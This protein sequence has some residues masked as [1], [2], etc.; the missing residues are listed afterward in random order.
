MHIAS[1]KLTNWECF[2][3]EHELALGSLIYAIT[4]RCGDDADR[5]NWAG[6]SSLL[7]AVEFALYG[8]HA[9]ARAN[10]WISRGEKAGSV[11]LA[12]D[13]GSRIIRSRTGDAATRVWFYPRA[14]E[15]AY[16]DA[17][18]EA[19][20][21]AIGLGAED[22]RASAYFEQRAMARFV[23]MDPGE[24]MR[25]VS[26]WLRM[27][28]LQR[29]EQAE[30]DAVSA[31]AAEVEKVE[32]S[33]AVQ[34]ELRDRALRNANAK[35]LTEVRRDSDACAADLL[36]AK[37]AYE[38]A[39][40]AVEANEALLAADALRAELAR[41]VE[42]GKALA[43]EVER[44]GQPALTDAD[45]ETV[46][47]RASRTAAD[48]ARF[49]EEA[50]RVDRDLAQKR[51][52]A[53]GQFDGACPVAQ[54]ECPAR[55]KINSM[56][57]EH[58]EA[59][60]ALTRRG[61]D[62]DQAAYHARE[63]A[64]AAREDLQD[65]ERKRARLESMRERAASLQERIE[66]AGE[67]SARP[68]EELRAALDRA[69][70]EVVEL[71]TEHEALRRAAEELAGA[72]VEIDKLDA[73]LA[74]LRTEQELARASLAVL[75]KQGAQ[76]RLAE[77]AL[78]DIEA[79]ANDL[80]S[81]SSIPLSVSVRWSREGSGLAQFCDACGLA[82][83]ASAKVKACTRCN[84][85]RGPNVVNRLE[86]ELS[87]RSGA[88]EDLAG[89]AVQLSASAWLRADRGSAWEVAMI[90]E[91]FAHCDKANRRAFATY[92]ATFLSRRL[93]IAQ[94]FIISHTPDT[95][96]MIPGRIEVVR[97]GEWSRVRVV[98]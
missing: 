7:R 30:R 83:P 24:R 53:A 1:L 63:D 12:L 54:I 87:D 3:G 93:A 36:A 91:P 95:V 82:F 48:A 75:G 55:A 16:G 92:L 65:L 68:R 28:P 84:A 14:G 59:V 17:A 44:L 80:L 69:Q 45:V 67:A 78:G 9:H 98:A 33:L 74:R 6:K 60:L 10:G 71:R 26:G 35:D 73:Q 25:I 50:K 76:R 70:G 38:E 81:G 90:D 32:R 41:L 20:E 34:R 89:A 4:A 29:A 37:V 97:E 77:G 51:R 8:R 27:E 43:A 31:L 5:S 85:A 15:P 46:E 13:D 62:A 64:R 11:E 56:R 2:R 88:A 47:E 72:E 94:S 57:D 23:L 52:L 79:G 86:V 42:D 66:A 18:Q 40:A 21:R 19:I 96:S 58:R 49:D 39:R 61:A 22:F